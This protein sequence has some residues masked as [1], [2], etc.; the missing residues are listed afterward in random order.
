M[1][2][3]IRKTHIILSESPSINAATWQFVFGSTI[4]QLNPVKFMRELL[5]EEVWDK[6]YMKYCPEW[7]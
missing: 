5:Y 7:F 1:A 2:I 3:H 4:M 6:M